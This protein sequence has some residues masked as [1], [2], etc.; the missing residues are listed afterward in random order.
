[1][2]SSLCSG[3][4]CT[5]SSLDSISFEDSFAYLNE[6]TFW[7]K[8]VS[9]VTSLMIHSLICKRRSIWSLIDKILCLV[10]LYP[11]LQNL[12]MGVKVLIFLLKGG[13]CV[14]IRLVLNLDLLLHDLLDLSQLIYFSFLLSSFFRYRVRGFLLLRWWQISS[15]FHI[16]TG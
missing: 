3:M 1:M 16:Y 13:S 15:L 14:S 6:L 9:S 10:Y 11:L 7:L 5:M 8:W 2:L 12:C 4:S